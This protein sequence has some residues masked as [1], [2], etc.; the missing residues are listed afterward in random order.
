MFLNL[1]KYFKYFFL[2]QKKGNPRDDHLENQSACNTDLLIDFDG[3]IFLLVTEMMY[4]IK[5]GEPKFTLF[6]QKNEKELF[7]N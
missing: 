5:K 4:R 2:P 1:P 3:Q 7:F 6:N